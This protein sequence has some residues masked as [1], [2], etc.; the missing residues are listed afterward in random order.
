MITTV[1]DER[2]DG[3]IKCRHTIEIYCPACGRDVDE[4]ELAALKC[5][6]CGYSLAAPKQSVSVEVANLSFGGLSF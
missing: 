2:V 1:P 3:E 4:A 6:D 5:N